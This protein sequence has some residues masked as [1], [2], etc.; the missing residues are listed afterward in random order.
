M[1]LSMTKLLVA[2]CAVHCS[3]ATQFFLRKH[4]LVH[5]GLAGTGLDMVFDSLLNLAHTADF[6]LRDMASDNTVNTIGVSIETESESDDGSYLEFPNKTGCERHATLEHRFT[7]RQ[8]WGKP[9]QAR[10]AVTHLAKALG[11][12]S[13]VTMATEISLIGF[14]GSMIP[15]KLVAEFVKPKKYTCP[16]CGQPCEVDKTQKQDEA[17]GFGTGKPCPI[18]AGLLHDNIS[19]VTPDQSKMSVLPDFL[20]VGTETIH[21]ADGSLALKITHKMSS[22]SRLDLMRLPRSRRNFP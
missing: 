8:L 9:L 2:C 4:H 3:R 1:T 13:N 16:V 21:H 11:E 22:V 12:G 10:S 7:C 18:A 14:W 19:G 15:D 5:Q 20:V 6:G 17:F